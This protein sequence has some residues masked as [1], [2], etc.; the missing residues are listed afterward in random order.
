MLLP[1]LDPGD[2]G[3]NRIFSCWLAGHLSL[4]GF[5][6]LLVLG[7]PLQALLLQTGFFRRKTLLGPLGLLRFD[8]QTLLLCLLDP[9]VVHQR[10]MAWADPGTGT[11]LDA[12]IQLMLSRLVM[13]SGLAKP[14]ELLR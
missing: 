12:I 10:D 13:L 1:G 4:S 2:G 3:G 11:T 7:F 14:V 6:H 5:D 8:G 9:V